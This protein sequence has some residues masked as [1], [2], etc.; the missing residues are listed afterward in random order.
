MISGSYTSQLAAVSYFDN[1]GGQGGAGGAV[2]T[3]GMG[4]AGNT[5]PIAPGVTA[6]PDAEGNCGC[7]TPGRRGLGASG[8]WAALG[9]GLGASVLRRR[10]R[11]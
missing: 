11:G 6:D 3:G 5:G 7:V 9:L 10:R 2:P 4:G 1:S 8:G